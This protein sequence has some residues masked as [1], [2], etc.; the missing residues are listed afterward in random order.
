[1]FFHQNHPGVVLFFGGGGDYN[2][3]GVLQQIQFLCKLLFI[4]SSN[5]CFADLRNQ[6]NDYFSIFAVPVCNVVIEG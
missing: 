1:M 3:W 2:F 6:M 4:V 5:C